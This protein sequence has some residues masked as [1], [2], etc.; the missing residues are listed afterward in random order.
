[1]IRARK[2]SIKAILILTVISLLTSAAVLTSIGSDAAETSTK[3]VVSLTWDDG[4]AS[5][6]DS[7]KIQEK[8]GMKATYYINSAGIGASPYYL[9]RAQL[10][11]IAAAGNEI[12]G[13]TVNHEL[14]TDLSI[15]KATKAIC[16]DRQTLVNWYGENAI[17]S[18]AYPF[19]VHNAE[20]Q[21]IPGSCGY[22]SAR[23]TYG[24][25][26]ATSCLGCQLAESL[27]PLNPWALLA[28]PSITATTTLDD[29]KY[30]VNQAAI[31][32]GGW[33]NL[34]FHSINSPADV[35]NI[36][37]AVYDEFLSW[38]AAQTDVVVKT[39]RE[40]MA[41]T[42][43]TP[44]TTSSTTTTT[45]T[46]PPLESV[47]IANDGLEADANANGVADCWLRG[48]AGSNTASWRRTG[49]A[50]TGSWAEE[51]T[52]TSFTSGD[53]KLVQLLDG[54]S[55]NGGCAPSVSDSSTYS[56]NVWYR[57]TGTSNFVVFTRDAAGV[58][59]YWKTGPKIAPAAGWTAAS[60]APGKLPVG[61][62]AL[63][64]GLA[65]TSAGT[66]ATDDYAMMKEPPPVVIPTD[67]AVKNSSFE[68][69]SNSDGLA[70]CWMRGGY[71]TST[72]S[73]QRVKDARTGTWGQKLTVSSYTSG[74]RKIMQPLDKGQAAGGCA[75]DVTPGKQYWL[76]S[77]YR[78]DATPLLFVYL[79]DTQGVWRWWIS[80]LP[81]QSATSWTKASFLTPPIPA[82]TTAMSFGLGIKGL[83]TLIVDDASSSLA[84]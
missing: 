3:I 27:P 49:D 66:L 6:F 62:T 59:K 84:G 41:T 14:L 7:L 47:P 76:S 5:Q 4:R 60:F 50:R 79:R 80:T 32:G 9:S 40:V 30:Q 42:W 11:S 77:W 43:P 2:R 57:S 38:I 17:R 52:I 18:F 64:F 31:N 26:T 55:A 68:V 56:L 82:G 23:T 16:D 75:L 35:Y 34:I 83:G 67:P 46:P 61:T 21:K 37:P 12:G 74:D 70:D 8:Y 19:G 1:M 73:F 28:P 36:E 13:H 48:S 45:T 78:S 39:V 10:D 44:T 20:I 71:G 65:L 22:T 54:G 63:S 33:V 25:R 24:V 15:E 81:N 53:R 58:W 72:F 69:D 51:V 29:L